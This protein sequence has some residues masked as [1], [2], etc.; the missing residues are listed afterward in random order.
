M[1]RTHT[2]SPFGTIWQT[3]LNYARINIDDRYSYPHHTSD[4]VDGCGANDDDERFPK[5]LR[6]CCGILEQNLLDISN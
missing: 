6:R 3:S 5:T 1:C 4:Q 2:T